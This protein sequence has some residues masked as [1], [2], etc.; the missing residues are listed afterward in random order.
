MKSK[1]TRTLEFSTLY[2]VKGLYSDEK[3]NEFNIFISGDKKEV[4]KF[5]RYQKRQ[6][7]KG[8][9]G[10]Y[11]TVTPDHS[12]EPHEMMPQQKTVRRRQQDFDLKAGKVK[13]GISR[14]RIVTQRP[15]KITYHIDPKIKTAPMGVNLNENVRPIP[16]FEFE[17]DGPMAEV[18]CT[19]Q[20]GKVE[21]ALIEVGNQGFADGPR[22]LEDIPNA[23]SGSLVAHAKGTIQKWRVEAI[24]KRPGKESMFDL[25]YTKKFG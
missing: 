2:T 18:T 24:G 14:H 21:F 8:I 9:V 10:I 11:A 1:K 4:D 12:P 3:G 22:V 7:E 5:I 6:L 17:F 19:V 13:I 20:T 25:E 16:D 23:N 15:Y